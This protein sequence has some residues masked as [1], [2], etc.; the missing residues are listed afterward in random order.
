MKNLITLGQLTEMLPGTKVDPTWINEEFEAVVLNV[1][2]KTTKANKTYYT[3]TLQDPHSTNITIDATS[4]SYG[5]S[6][7]QGKVCRF[8][9]QGMKLDSYKGNLKLVIGDKTTINVVGA[10]PSG[11]TNTPLTAPTP[12]QGQGNG[13][14]QPATSTR[15]IHGATV[16]MAINQAIAIILGNLAPSEDPKA[17]DRYYMSPAFGKDL[18]TLASDIIRVAAYLEA[19]HL[20]ESSA[21]RAAPTHEIAPVPVAAPVPV[22][23]S[24]PKPV[25]APAQEED[26]SENVPF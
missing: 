2:T 23:A 22:P 3:A 11:H 26:D 1:E 19:G 18:H 10:A 4:W 12:L 6:S 7:K 5:I 9:G 16:G 24:A 8:G 14:G 17:L 25:P 15:P 13:Q 20:A 21:R